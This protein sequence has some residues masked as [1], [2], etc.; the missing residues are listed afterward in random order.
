[1]TSYELPEKMTACVLTRPGAFEIQHDIP[2]PQPGP[3]EVLCKIQAVAIC[4]SDPEI[5]RLSLIHI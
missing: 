3:D 1:M 4:G 5:F 2:V